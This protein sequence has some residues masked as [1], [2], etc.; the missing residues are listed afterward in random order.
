M[1][2]SHSSVSLPK[3][4]WTTVSTRF[5]LSSTD[6]VQG[7]SSL[8]RSLYSM[9]CEP[10]AISSIQVAI[11]TYSLDHTISMYNPSSVFLEGSFRETLLEYRIAICV[12]S[13]D[14]LSF[15]H[16]AWSTFQSFSWSLD[17]L[18]SSISF[19]CWALL[20]EFTMIVRPPIAVVSLVICSADRC[21]PI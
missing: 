5:Y 14:F 4:P 21:C 12:L 13:L 1:L 15:C 17:I 9:Q 10:L 7:S 3:I 11:E 6:Q 20:L 19:F 18:L 2:G 8:N 16:I